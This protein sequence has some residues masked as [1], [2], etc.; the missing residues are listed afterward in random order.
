M[1]SMLFPLKTYKNLSILS[2]SLLKR[3]SANELF[4]EDSIADSKRE[5]IGT[6]QSDRLFEDPTKEEVLYI[7][8]LKADL[9]R[10]GVAGSHPHQR[11]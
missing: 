9:K 8:E 1:A 4:N 2:S 6:R 7:E 3:S 10:V 11:C 5:N